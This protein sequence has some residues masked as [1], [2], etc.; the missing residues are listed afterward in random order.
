MNKNWKSSLIN[1][2]LKHNSQ[3][4]KTCKTKKI[5]KNKYLIRKIKIKKTKI[6]RNNPKIVTFQTS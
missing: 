5:R 2:K 6:N 3:I 1:K 4:R